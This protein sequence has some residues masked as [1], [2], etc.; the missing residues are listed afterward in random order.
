MACAVYW[1]VRLAWADHLA[2]GD[3]LQQAHAAVALAANNAAYWL[4]VADL[5]QARGES[6]GPGIAEAVRVD[7]Y[8]AEV[9]MRAG[10]LAEANG[11]L[12]RAEQDLLRAARLSRQFEPRWTLANYYFRRNDLDRFW[13]WAHSALVASFNERWLLFDL[14]WRIQPD[15]GVILSRAIP[16]NSEVL[17]DYLSYLLYHNHLEASLPVAHKLEAEASEQDREP[18][19]RYANRMLDRRQWQAAL[20]AWNALCLRKLVRY[21]PLDA[22]R[23]RLVTNGDFRA[24]PLDSGFDWRLPEV[25]GVAAVY[26]DSPPWLRFDFSGD[27]PEHCNVVYQ[28]VPVEA[29]SRY[30]LRFTYRTEGIQPGTGLEW[31][32]TDAATGGEIL[33]PPLHLSSES[34][35]SE[36]IAFAAPAGMQAA[37]VTLDYRR[38]PGTVRIEGT[39]WLRNVGLE[40]LP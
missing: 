11:D 17:R 23:G 10:L 4:R 28:F 9:W 19:L 1:S 34:W 16:D 2:K 35:T 13:P 18:L 14:C 25:S 12:A 15:A 31:K 5:E 30:A 6:G 26:S 33:T 32:V 7:P 39:V 22:G 36:G 20:S 24:Q 29:G 37:A 21:A 8:D 38:Q 3:S 27:Q 40:R